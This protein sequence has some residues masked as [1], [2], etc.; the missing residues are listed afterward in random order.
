MKYTTVPEIV[1]GSVDDVD[2]PEIKVSYERDSRKTFAQVTSSSDAA[3][4]I[5]KTFNKGEI[6]LQEQFIVLYLNQ[7]NNIIGY[8]RHS[9]GAIN[10]TIA[11][12]RIILATALKSAAV[13]MI[14][15]HNHPTG[16][17]RPSMAR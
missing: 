15:A 3:E 4:F 11:D 7:S 10:A 2:V 12:T 9:K 16:N 14:V 1:L 13:G 6:E 8:Y 17:L 5:R